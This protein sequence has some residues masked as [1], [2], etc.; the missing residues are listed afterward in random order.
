MAPI[1]YPAKLT[2]SLKYSEYG[3]C[4]ALGSLD[5]GASDESDMAEVRETGEKGFRWKAGG[6]GGDRNPEFDGREPRMSADYKH[7]RVQP[8]GHG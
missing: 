2:F 7:P 8:N 4:G 1:G 6:V 3:I 5:Q